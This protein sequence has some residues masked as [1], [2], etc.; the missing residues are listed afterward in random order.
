MCTCVHVIYIGIYV[1]TCVCL[2]LYMKKTLYKSLNYVRNST[3]GVLCREVTNSYYR[4]KMR[5]ILLLIIKLWLNYY[6]NYELKKVDS[7]TETIYKNYV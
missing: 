1:S 2:Y 3:E 6:V 5:W 7:F 4:K